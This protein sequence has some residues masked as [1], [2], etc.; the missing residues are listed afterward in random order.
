MTS[1]LLQGSEV[2]WKWCEFIAVLYLRM[3][4]YIVSG[5]IFV[6]YLTNS[7]AK[8]AKWPASF[9]LALD[10]LSFQ[11]QT[12]FPCGKIFF[13]FFFL[14]KHTGYFINFIRPWFIWLLWLWILVYHTLTLQGLPYSLATASIMS[15]G[16]TECMSCNSHWNQYGLRLGACC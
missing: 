3:P 7:V 4:C 12:S 5:R 9:L 15:C 14:M 16:C 1:A 11:I 2:V 10:S 8:P 6:W 13:F